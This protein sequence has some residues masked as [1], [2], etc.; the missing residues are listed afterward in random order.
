MAYLVVSL[1]SFISKDFR[2]DELSKI[3]LNGTTYDFSADQSVIEKE[4]TLN[5]LG[6]SI[7]KI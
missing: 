1:L 2:K 6:Y 4:G 3:L 5:I 7:K